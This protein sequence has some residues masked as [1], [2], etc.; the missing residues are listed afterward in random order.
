MGR[1][2]EGSVIKKKDVLGSESKKGMI[3]IKTASSGV[4]KM[5]VRKWYEEVAVEE[6]EDME[7]EE[8]AHPVPTPL[9]K[10]KSSLSRHP[11]PAK[12]QPRREGGVDEEDSAGEDELTL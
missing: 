12:Q 6:E 8:E 9:G 3:A 5:P 10:R 11:S 1:G 2:G 4:E 7:D